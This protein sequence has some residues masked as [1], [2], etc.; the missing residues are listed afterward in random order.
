MLLQAVP[1]SAGTL[2]EIGCGLARAAHDLLPARRELV[3]LGVDLDPE[4]LATAWRELEAASYGAR[5]RLLRAA[6]ERL[7]LADGAVDVV[8]TSMTLQH[9]RDVG[10]VLGEARRV[11]RTGGAVV[12]VEP[13]HLAHRWYFERPL[14]PIIAA[15]AALTARLQAARLPADLSIG[16]RLAS[17]MRAAGFADVAVDVHLL[18][19]GG[20][21]TAGQVAAELLEHADSLAASAPVPRDT[22]APCRAAVDRWVAETGAQTV[23]QYAWMV[24]V[25]VTCGRREWP[26]PYS[27]SCRGWRWCLRSRPAGR[28]PRARRRRPRPHR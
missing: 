16:P 12:T 17:H 14:E 15:F 5:G 4:R 1:A 20:V 21:R 10:I 19:H 25:F 13:D 23:G 27:G 24:P 11:L 18:Q 28:R 6:G 9:V 26:V 2:L 22:A 3:Y 8:L 7:P